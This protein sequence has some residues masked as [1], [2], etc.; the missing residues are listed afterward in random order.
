MEAEHGRYGIYVGFRAFGLVIFGG[1]FGF[2]GFFG[3]N[4]GRRMEK[5]WRWT[6]DSGWW[7]FRWI[8]YPEYLRE[9]FL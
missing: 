6:V 7:M 1:F 5:E 4:G 9:V 8:K 3:A 2:L